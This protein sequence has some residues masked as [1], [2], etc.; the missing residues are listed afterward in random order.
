M[1]KNI[2]SLCLLVSLILITGAG[3]SR[4]SNSTNPNEEDAV[5]PFGEDLSRP[6]ADLENINTWRTFLIKE[7]GFSIKFPFLPGQIKRFDD[8]FYSFVPCDKLSCGDKQY[9]V[10]GDYQDRY[11]ILGSVSKNYEIGSSWQIHEL[12]DIDIKSDTVVLRGPQGKTKEVKIFK[13]FKNDQ[14]TIEGVIVPVKNS[15]DLTTPEAFSGSEGYAAFFKLS[16]QNKNFK[17]AVF[18][19]KSSDLPLDTFEKALHSIV[20]EAA[21]PVKK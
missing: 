21:S 14:G 4:R 8:F 17:A 1:K 6:Q 18:Y 19:L 11:K 2:L 16:P 5:E 9:A 3:C 12:H 13:K 15:E 10:F 7:L 20:M